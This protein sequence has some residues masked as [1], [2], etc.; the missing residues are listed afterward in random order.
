MS[1]DALTSAHAVGSPPDTAIEDWVRLSARRLPLRTPAQL[2]QLQFHC[3]KPPPAAEPSTRI[4]TPFATC[5]GRAAHRPGS[6]Y[7]WPSNL[8]ERR[9]PPAR[10][11]TS[12]ISTIGD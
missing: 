8:E 7:S 12:A 5:S 1:G 3:G 6:R 10:A 9:G 4:F 11:R 2:R